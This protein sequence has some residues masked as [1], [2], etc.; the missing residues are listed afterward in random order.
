MKHQL[1]LASKYFGYL[2]ELSIYSHFIK[3][4][5]LYK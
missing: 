1:A 2:L 3:L 4:N 5:T